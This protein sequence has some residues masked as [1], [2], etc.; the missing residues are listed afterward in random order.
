MQAPSRSDIAHRCASTWR[1]SQGWQQALVIL[2]CRRTSVC[3]VHG[4][5]GGKNAKEAEV[6]EAFRNSA[7][8]LPWKPWFADRMSAGA[9]EFAVYA[10]CD[11]NLACHSE[12][13]QRKTTGD[14]DGLAQQISGDLQQLRD[15]LPDD[16]HKHEADWRRIIQYYNDRNIRLS[17]KGIWQPI[18]EEVFSDGRSR[19]PP[20]PIDIRTLPSNLRTDPFDAG[21]FRDPVLADSQAWGRRVPTRSDPT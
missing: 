6:T 5:G 17:P 2:D 14:W 3:S 12:S 16:Q 20:R 13:I 7:A 11:Q 19:D 1:A 4:R 21:N 9:A 8:N 10:Y 18:P 15:V